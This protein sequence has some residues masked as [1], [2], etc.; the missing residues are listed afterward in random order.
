MRSPNPFTTSRITKIFYP[1]LSTGKGSSLTT[2]NHGEC[3]GHDMSR[4]GRT[5]PPAPRLRPI[6]LPTVDFTGRRIGI[7]SF[8]RDVDRISL[9]R[10]QKA[11]FPYR[12]RRSYIE[13]SHTPSHTHRC[14][15]T[16]LL[17]PQPSALNLTICRNGLSG[18]FLPELKWSATAFRGRLKSFRHKTRL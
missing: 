3:S 16:S 14:H 10:F 13:V 18:P 1:V 7:Y 9:F 8:L 17:H 12:G 15:T 6:P 2:R 4:N 5:P 11:P